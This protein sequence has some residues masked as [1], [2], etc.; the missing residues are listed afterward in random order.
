M[1]SFV[2]GPDLLIYLRGSISTLV[3]QI[4]KRGRAYENNIRIDYLSRLN[5]RYEAWNSSYDKGKM[6]IVD[7]DNNKFAH[8]PEHLGEIINRIDGEINGLF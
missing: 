3:D 6:M 5:E 1:D 7:V 4:Q 2:Q 8:D